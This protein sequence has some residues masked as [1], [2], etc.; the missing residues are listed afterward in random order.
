LLPTDQ[1]RR[2]LRNGQN[3]RID[4]CGQHVRKNDASF[5]TSAEENIRTQ[6]R[7]IAGPSQV[8]A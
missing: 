1:I 8:A 4:V 3:R 6:A 5:G 2:S 7:F